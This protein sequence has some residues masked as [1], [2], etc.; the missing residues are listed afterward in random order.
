[1]FRAGTENEAILQGQNNM[2]GPISSQSRSEDTAAIFRLFE[3]SDGPSSGA[4]SRFRPRFLFTIAFK[5]PDLRR[6]C[7][8]HWA[9]MAGM[10]DRVPDG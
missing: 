4:D 3:L 6:R 7:R 2:D 8:S 1:M 10:C 5:R 9:A